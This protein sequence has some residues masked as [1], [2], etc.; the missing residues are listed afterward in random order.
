MLTAL[1]GIY[2]N[3]RIILHE[4]PP[5][6][7]ETDVIVTFLEKEEGGRHNRQGGSMKGEVWM[8]DDFN[9]PLNDLNEYM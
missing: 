5:V 3:G 6:Q 9:E 7:E 2:R 1:K 8:T 4:T